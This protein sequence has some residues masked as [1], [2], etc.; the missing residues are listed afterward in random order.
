MHQET[1]CSQTPQ[2]NSVAERKNRHILEITRALLTAA[3]VLKRFWPD[4]VMTTVYLMNQ[5]PSQVLHYKTPLQVLAQHMTL[6]SVLMLPLRKFGC[7]TYVHIHKNQ[8]TKLDPC[9][10]RC[11]FLGYVAHKKGYRCYDPTIRRL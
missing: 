7:V 11:V 9:V 8:R 3:Y 1:S 6:P 2:Q 5:L 10:V 4:A